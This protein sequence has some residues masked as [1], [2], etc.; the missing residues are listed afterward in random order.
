MG[1]YEDAIE[2][3]LRNWPGVEAEFGRRAKHRQVILRFGGRSRFVVYPDSPSDHRGCRN[4]IIDIRKECASLGAERSRPEKVA[5]RR[6]TAPR[7]RVQ[8]H[9]WMDRIERA[10]V[11][12][13]PFAILAQIAP[14]AQSAEPAPHKGLDAGSTPARR[15]IWQRIKAW[16]AP[17]PIAPERGL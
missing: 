6:K 10:P 17:S 14:V 2:H 8:R 7:P 3:E 9:D 1:A 15:T 13:D 11:K 5:R 4:N 16:F 12:P